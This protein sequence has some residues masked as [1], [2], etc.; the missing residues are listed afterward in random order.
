MG[1]R[2]S[3]RRDCGSRRSHS[4]GL[5]R[6][7]GNGSERVRDLGGRVSYFIEVSLGAAIG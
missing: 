2:E 4:K 7:H 5:K 1:E 3:G 6:F